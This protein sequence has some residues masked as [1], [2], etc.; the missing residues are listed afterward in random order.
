MKK[1]QIHN[2]ISV[3]ENWRGV[4]TEGARKLEVQNLK[5]REF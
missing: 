5:G 3:R 1:R 4:K 2:K